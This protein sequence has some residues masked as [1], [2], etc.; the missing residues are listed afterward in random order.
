VLVLIS[1]GQPNVPLLPGA[2]VRREL[3]Q[4]GRRVHRDHIHGVVID[5]A[6]KARTTG[7]MVQLAE[8]LGGTYHHID[9]LRPGR[10]V[11]VVHA[12]VGLA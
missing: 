7:I 9:A 11:A 6:P 4:L 1:D 3:L 12:S 2:H 5:T 8:A 10:V